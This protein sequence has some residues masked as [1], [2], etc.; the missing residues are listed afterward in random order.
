MIQSL[1]FKGMMKTLVI[2]SLL[3]CAAI[4]SSDH[5]NYPNPN[6]PTSLKQEVMSPPN[7][8]SNVRLS[9]IGRKIFATMEPK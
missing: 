1:N 5:L 2:F 3:F 6:P 9:A 7:E 4:A 8:V